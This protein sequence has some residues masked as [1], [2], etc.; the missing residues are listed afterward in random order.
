MITKTQT[1]WESM[2]EENL[3]SCSPESNSYTKQFNE[4][5]GCTISVYDSRGKMLEVKSVYG[6]FADTNAS[7][8]NCVGQCNA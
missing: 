5:K 4:E 1:L 2:Q 8:V 3:A 7:E 6:A